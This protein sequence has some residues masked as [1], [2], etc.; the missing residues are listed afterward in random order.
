MPRAYYTVDEAA[1]HLN[2]SRHT[3]NKWRSQKRGPRFI[4]FGKSVRY[5]HE[6]LATFASENCDGV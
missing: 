2:M 3:L 5:R 4:R 6:D 1:A